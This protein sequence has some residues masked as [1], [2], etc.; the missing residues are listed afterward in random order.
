VQQLPEFDG[1]NHGDGDVWYYISCVNTA[2]QVKLLDPSDIL[3]GVEAMPN[4]KDQPEEMN[5]DSNR[6]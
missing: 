5:D 6:G 4:I 3:V 1:A 2:V